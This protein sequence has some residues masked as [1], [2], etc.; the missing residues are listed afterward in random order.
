MWLQT[1]CHEAELAARAPP[2]RVYEA[3]KTA[4]GSCVSRVYDLLGCF[5]VPESLRYAG[6]QCLH[7]FFFNFDVLHVWYLVKAATAFKGIYQHQQSNTSLKSK[8][9]GIISR[10]WA[11][12]GQIISRC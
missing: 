6:C 3:A 9:K 10:M 2:S 1:G 7:S 8:D 12:N 4:Q 5:A 11:L